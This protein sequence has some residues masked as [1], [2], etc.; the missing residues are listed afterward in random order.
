MGIGVGVISGVAVGVGVGMEVGL[1]VA[2]GGG[3]L[4]CPDTAIC[5]RDPF[6]IR[7]DLK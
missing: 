4:N 3:G 1:G 5:P 7:S 6:I 2:F